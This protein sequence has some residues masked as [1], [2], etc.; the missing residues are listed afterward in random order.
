[1]IQYTISV[2][3]PFA[4]GQAAERVDRA[5]TA[6]LALLGSEG[7]YLVQRGIAGAGRVQ[8]GQ[9]RGSIFT[10]AR[11]VPFQRSQVIASSVFYA[12]IV[13]QGRRPGRRPPLAPI[14]LWVRRKLGVGPREERQVAFL[15]AR[16]I[17]RVGFAGVHM[18][19]NATT[20]LA[21]IVA[22][23]VAAMRD[24]LVRDLSG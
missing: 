18:F 24:T 21:P 5:L 2:R 15:V 10:E 19:R 17:G 16:K 3:G 7:Q 9:L 23:R 4:T 20:A 14:R 8:T 6:T 22:K 12:P 11:G 13:E 1:V